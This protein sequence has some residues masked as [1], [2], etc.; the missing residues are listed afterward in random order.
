LAK[1]KQKNLLCDVAAISPGGPVKSAKHYHNLWKND[2]TRYATFYCGPHCKVPLK[3]AA[4]YRATSALVAH[5]K[6]LDASHPHLDG[7]AYIKERQ[8]SIGGSSTNTGVQTALQPASI[9]IEEDDNAGAGVRKRP[10]RDATREKSP[11]SQSGR[12]SLT[13]I[14]ESYFGVM[15]K[16]SSTDSVSKKITTNWDNFR[17]ELKSLPLLLLGEQLNYRSA[18]RTTRYAHP[19]GAGPRI[20]HSVGKVHVSQIS[21]YYFFYSRE[22]LVIENN[23]TE[24]SVY[25]LIPKSLCENALATKKYSETARALER[26][27][28]GGIEYHWFCVGILAKNEK[29]DT[30]DG[31]QITLETL[32][33]LRLF[34]P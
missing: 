24:Q 5:F 1:A 22:R 21:G 3:A 19:I 33:R 6:I 20:Y 25:F 34:E 30:F 15:E 4:V 18:F 10:Q 23:E 7:C 32:Q 26:A 16:H 8:K 29:A 12:G 9:Y 11:M 27:S 17:E 14:I 2:G 31:Y 13:S 28:K